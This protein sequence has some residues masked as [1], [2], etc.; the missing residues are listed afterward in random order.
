MNPTKRTKNE[1][2]RPT[3]GVSL[4]GTPGSEFLKTVT[5]SLA[6][7]PGNVLVADTK[8]NIRYVSPRTLSALGYD[9]GE[10]VGRDIT[11][12][13]DQPE[14]ISRG[15]LARLKQ[16]HFWQGKIKQKRKSDGS[17]GNENSFWELVSLSIVAES[18]VEESYIIKNGQPIH[19]DKHGEP[20]AARDQI[21]M[22]HR[23]LLDAYPYSITIFRLSDGKL[24]D[25]NKSFCQN[26]GYSRQEV[27]GRTSVELG[28]YKDLA[29][30]EKFYKRFKQDS[31]VD[32]MEIQYFSKT[33][34]IQY[35]VISA[36]RIDF[37]G[38]ACGITT[39]MEITEL[40]KTQRELKESELRYRTIMEATPDP[41]TLTRLSDEKIVQS[42]TAFC[43]R[44]GWS[45]EET[46]GRTAME[47]D[48]YENPADRDRFLDILQK[49][50]QV[51]AF[52]VSVRYKDGTT[53]F[54]VL[55]GRVIDILN[56]P[57]MLVVTRDVGELYATQKALEESERNYRTILEMSPNTISVT[58]LSDLR[59]LLVNEAFA[60]D[61][62]YSREEVVGKRT[63]DLNFFED[64][65]EIDRFLKTFLSEGHVDGMELR[66]KRKD[67]RITESL[68][69]ARPIQY[70]NEPCMLAIATNIDTLKETQRALSERET[71]YRTILETAPY[72]IIVTRLSDGVFIEVN[73]VCCRRLGLVREQIIGQTALSLNLYK[74]PADRNRLIETLRRDGL[75]MDMEI[76]YLSN[77][78]TLLQNLVSAA[79][80]KYNGEECMIVMTVDIGKLK[81]AEK[82]LRSSEQKYR[83]VLMNMEEGY[84]EVDFK[85]NYTFVNEAQGRIHGCT[86]KELIGKNNRD[87][88]SPETAKRAFKL[89]NSV[90]KTGIPAMLNDYELTRKDG[91]LAV[92]ESSVSLQKDENG[93]PVGY[94]GIA[95]DITEKKKAADELQKYRQHLEQMVRERT[96]KLES[97]QNELVKREKLSVLGQLTATVSHELRNPI[98]VIK[99]S[100]YFLK[101]RIGQQD[102]KAIKHFKRID[103]QVNL[104]DLIVA[105][106]LEYTRGRNIELI[107]RPITPWLEQVIQQLEETENITIENN[108]CPSLPPVPH[109]QEKMRRVCINLIENAVHAVRARE[110]AEAADTY[111][112][113][114]CV[115]TTQED[116]KVVIEVRDNGIG[117]DETTREHAFEPLFTTRAQGTG[118]GLAN[119]QKIVMEHNGEVLLASEPGKGTTVTIKLKCTINAEGSSLEPEENWDSENQ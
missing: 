54:C 77:D 9:Q 87:Y 5:H 13:W 107:Q 84:W 118:I 79:P 117:M 99:S 42:N 7:V 8:G 2:I 43:Q 14:E 39:S 53:S 65:A 30:R 21:E 22:D 119:V 10:M 63:L 94:F 88:T 102:E 68:I 91:S 106:L 93:K 16:D 70:A 35:A 4:P 28:L 49:E 37:Q 92:M 81:E 109:D 15:I 57:H 24:L 66:F 32:E 46:I 12:F 47:L 20:D 36:K 6:Y 67:G 111:Q 103:D 18:D 98:A 115:T 58:R 41:I 52:L 33:G 82:A 1:R 59:H 116:R 25:V 55:A 96:H 72:S 11:S 73:Q 113:N 104:C 60:R 48:L 71:N 3:G 38:V 89:F 112:P 34:E 80:I 44:T 110:R 75:V 19:Q 105:D 83:N 50:G 108:L 62:G 97:A 27:L 101:Q 40:K 85:G 114:I 78:G 64:H 51:D 17:A 95:R 45:P 86:A 26:T 61:T 23:A 74:N 56:E 69:S 76:S 31:R 29:T 100:N 90:Y